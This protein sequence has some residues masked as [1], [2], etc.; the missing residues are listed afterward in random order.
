MR[1]AVP[2]REELLLAQVRRAHGQHDAE[3]RARGADGGRSRAKFHG[4]RNTAKETLLLYCKMTGG[5]CSFAG[6]TARPGC[7]ALGLKGETKRLTC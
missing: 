7:K 6:F 4:R 3:L 5:M 1:G 2:A